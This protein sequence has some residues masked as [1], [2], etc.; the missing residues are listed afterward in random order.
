[1]ESIKKFLTWWNRPNKSWL[2]DNIQAI[3]VI[4]PLAILI[5][6]FGFGLYQVP[7]GSMETT[8][9]VGERFFADKLMPLVIPLK[10][11]SIISFNDPTFKY[12]QN[13]FARWFQNNFYWGISNWTKRVIAL[14]GD[15][16]K[17]VVENSKPVVYLNG[18]KL[19]EPYL[20]KYPLIALF[21]HN[22]Q[23]PLEY[24]SYDS[25]KKYEDQPFYTM[26]DYDVKA[27]KKIAQLI[28]QPDMK[29][30]GTPLDVDLGFGIEKNADTFDV[31]LADNEYW[32]MGDNRLGSHDS[33]A[34]GPLKGDNIH[35][36][37]VWRLWS[38][39]SDESWWILDLIKHPINFWKKVRWSRCFN[40]M[41]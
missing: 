14:P 27:G 5:R 2:M 40:T 19:D 41:H 26:T 7:S 38:I 28:H 11:G 29:F 30:P 35:G 13:S 33:R 10:R 3:I 12:S 24:R 18:K 32:V 9:L 22:N 20:N 31:Q 37:I 17:G 15:H 4:V 1:M 6:T 16:V 34:W 8:M 21:S 23:N 39:D 36:K 25:E